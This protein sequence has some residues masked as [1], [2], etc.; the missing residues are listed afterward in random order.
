MNE[1][2][3]CVIC[4]KEF[5]GYGNNPY[6]IKED[7]RCCDIC[8]L[9]VIEKRLSKLKESDTMDDNTIM[10]VD[11][12]KNLVGEMDE[13]EVLS[14]IVVL[15]VDYLDKY[16]NRDL[17]NTLKLIKKGCKKYLEFLKESE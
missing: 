15:L 5:V 10:S 17:S 12:I 6:P 14:T 1:K 7:G 8:N 11:Y 3:T 2:Y 13:S 9:K 16:K 4:G